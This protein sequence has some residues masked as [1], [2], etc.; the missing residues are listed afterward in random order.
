MHSDSDSV[1]R[2]ETRAQGLR[3][4]RNNLV[5]SL[6]SGSM[7]ALISVKYIAPSRIGFL[8]GL[9]AGFVYAN[10]F[11]YC[12]HR[13]LLHCGQGVFSQQHMVHHTTLK[14]P[15]AARYVN[16]SSNPWGVVPLFYA[17]AVPFFAPGWL[18][19]NRWEARA[20]LRFS[21]YPTAFVQLPGPRH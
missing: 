11:E 6:L 2:A 17:N 7:L 18:F 3:T 8:F 13:F 10:G 1:I 16:F 14:S 4:K 20:F 19:H 5:A 15:D 12:L 21:L 9:L